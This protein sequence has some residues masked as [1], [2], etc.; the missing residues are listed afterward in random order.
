MRDARF[1]AVI[2]NH[3]LAL[4]RYWQGQPIKLKPA[5]AR[6]QVE[7]EVARDR[8]AAY[9]A[10]LP[11]LIDLGTHVVV[12][13][14]VR[15]GVPMNE[16]TVADL[17]ELRTLGPDRTSREGLPWYALYPGPQTVLFGHWPASGRGAPATPSASIRVASTAFN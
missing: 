5:Q 7:L 13:A 9:L 1:A 15:P 10:G 3:D 12:H 4:L 2:G 6:A 16:Q 8:Y 17:T 14:G 11:A